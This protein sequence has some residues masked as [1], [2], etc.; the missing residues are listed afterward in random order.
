MVVIRLSTIR[1]RYDQGLN[2]IVR[3]VIQFEDRIEDLTALH[4]AAPRAAD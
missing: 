1:R 3:L 4:V 2:P